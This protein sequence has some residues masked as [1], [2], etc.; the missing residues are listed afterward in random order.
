M[1]ANDDFHVDA[2]FAG[3]AQDFDHAPC[4]RQTALWDTAMI[5]TSTTAPS[6]FRKAHS[7]RARQ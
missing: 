1:L 3:A 5:S 4:G 7:A 6:K 2:D